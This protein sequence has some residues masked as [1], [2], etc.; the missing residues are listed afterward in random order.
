[1][2]CTGLNKQRDTYVHACGEGLL[3]AGCDVRSGEK[4][5]ANIWLNSQGGATMLSRSPPPRNKGE[6]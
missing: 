3:W 4:W 5:A 2:T 1:M 6:L